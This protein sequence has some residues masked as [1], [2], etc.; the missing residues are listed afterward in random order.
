[1]RSQNKPKQHRRPAPRQIDLF[2]GEPERVTANVPLWSALPSQI[3]AAVTMLMTQLLLEHSQKR[4]WD[5]D[6]ESRS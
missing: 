6:R 5:L 1:M 3:Q 4:H 2:A